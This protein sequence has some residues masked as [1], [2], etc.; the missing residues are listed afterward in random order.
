MDKCEVEIPET[1]PEDSVI[2]PCFC[3][4]QQS[5]APGPDDAD[6]AAR[7]DFDCLSGFV[8]ERVAPE[9]VNERGG[10]KIGW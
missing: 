5:V 3:L 6:A 2:I 8:T 4:A 1:G 10:A 9:T 7:G